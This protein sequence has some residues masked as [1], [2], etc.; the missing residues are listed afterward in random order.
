MPGIR[1]LSILT[2]VL[3]NSGSITGLGNILLFFFF[4][5]KEISVPMVNKTNECLLNGL[6]DTAFLQ[7][8]GYDTFRSK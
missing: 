8:T 4:K 6:S 5:G 2:L 1:S 3:I 7:P